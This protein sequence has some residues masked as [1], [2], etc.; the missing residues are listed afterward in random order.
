NPGTTAKLELSG[1]GHDPSNPATVTV[2][3]KCEPGQRLFAMAGSRGDTLPV[4][5]VVTRLP[6]RLE[7]TD[8]P[9]GG[10]PERKPELQLALCRRL[11]Q[12]GDADG[13]QFEARKDLIYTFE[14]VARRAGSA[15]DPILRLMDGKG[16]TLSE[17]DDTRG[18][19]KDTRI[20]WKAPANGTY[21]IQVADLHDRRGDAYGYVFL[22][23]APAP[24]F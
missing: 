20:E 13:Y 23:E 21:T 14:V 3:A 22:A 6:V 11:G 9:A 1:P 8:V 4:P 18:L 16:S 2:P 10:E 7:T 24:H 15:C 19:G 12:Q 17:A 5:L